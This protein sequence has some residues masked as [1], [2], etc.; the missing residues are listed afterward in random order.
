[1][2]GTVCPWLH[3]RRSQCHGNAV[4]LDSGTGISA[5]LGGGVG[6]CIMGSKAC[7]TL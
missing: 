2:K 1:M 7:V 5:V 3:Q 4:S 6:N